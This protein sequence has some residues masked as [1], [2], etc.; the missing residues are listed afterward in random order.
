MPRKK[1]KGKKRPENWRARQKRLREMERSLKRKKLAPK[2]GTS[3]N[4]AKAQVQRGVRRDRMARNQLQ[5]VIEGVK[6]MLEDNRRSTRRSAKAKT[7]KTGLKSSGKT[8]TPPYRK[9]GQI[10]KVQSV[11]DA[12]QRKRLGNIKQTRARVGSQGLGPEPKRSPAK[13]QAKKTIKGRVAQKRQLRLPTQAAPRTSPQVWSKPDAMRTQ[14]K[15]GKYN[16]R[17]TG[18]TGPQRQLPPAGSTRGKRIKADGMTSQSPRHRN[19]NTKSAAK[20]RARARG[21]KGLALR[22]AGLAD[23]LGLLNLGLSQV[24]GPLGDFTRASNAK[25]NQEADD[26]NRIAIEQGANVL[27]GIGIL[28]KKSRSPKLGRN[29]K[30]EE[31]QMRARARRHQESK[32]FRQG[33]GTEPKR[34][35][36]SSSSTAKR[37]T[38]PTRTAAG[39]V[40]NPFRGGGNGEPVS[41]R[42]GRQYTAPRRAT[43]QQRAY[44]KDSRNREYDRLRRAGKFKEADAL[45]KKIAADHRKKAPKNPYR[46]PQGK[47]RTDTMYKQVQELRA[48][49]R[50]RKKR[51]GPAY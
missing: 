50:K 43:K 8:I 37:K 1:S 22:G 49:G 5:T 16:N 34:G 9:G 48:M 19:V 17:S 14:A 4:S 39:P 44:A 15:P 13:P 26:V 40:R 23:G 45:G 20:T 24:P 12:M 6:R 28:P 29:Y 46:A 51:F 47:E 33:I 32:R 31:Q 42:A 38:T 18:R 2:G 11:R 10:K 30:A 25:F 41:G 36:S 7:Q 21:M 35:G 27:R 3:A